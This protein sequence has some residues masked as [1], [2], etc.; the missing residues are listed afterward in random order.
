MV[1][2]FGLS[3]KPAGER[4]VSKVRPSL[5]SKRNPSHIIAGIRVH[6]C[7][8]AAQSGASL[9]LH[10][11]SSPVLLSAPEWIYDKT[12]GIVATAN[13]TFTH[14]IIEDLMYVGN[15]TVLEEVKGFERLTLHGV[16]EAAK[17]WIVARPRSTL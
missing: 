14:A 6:L 11:Y 9:F 12:E 13:A 15:W 10:E 2:L 16:Q 4:D 7:N 8:L 3:I 17:L 5:I 1:S